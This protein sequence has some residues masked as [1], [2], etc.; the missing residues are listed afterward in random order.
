MF[1]FSITNSGELIYNHLI[2]DVDKVEKDDLTKQ[3]AVNRIK[4]VVGNWFN[5]K[6]GANLEK[7]IGMANTPDTSVEIM[8]SIIDALTFDGFLEKESIYQIP[9]LDKTNLSIKL[10]IKKQFENDPIVIDVVVD[11]SSGVRVSYGTDK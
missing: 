10:F 8:E 7:Y 4:S 2:Q 3:I 5:T 11:I 1:D 6:I 9:R